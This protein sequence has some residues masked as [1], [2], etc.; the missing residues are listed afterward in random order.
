[1]KIGIIG[2]GNMGQALGLG[3]AR[4]GHEVLFGSRDAKKAKAIAAD[5]FRLHAGGRL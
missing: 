1:M 4:T 5:G 3:W 2:T